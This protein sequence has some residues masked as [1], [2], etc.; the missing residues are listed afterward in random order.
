MAYLGVDIGGTKTLVGVLDDSGVIQ[1]ELKFPTPKD[2]PEFLTGLKKTIEGFKTKEFKA[3]GVAA[4]GSLDRK[5]GV[6]IALGNLP[7]INV[8]MKEDVEKVTNS[9]VVIENDAGLAGLSEAQLVKNEY[10]KVLYLTISTGI[11]G[12]IIIDGIIQP[13]FADTEP[14]QME[15]E[16]NGSMQKWEDFASGR[17]IVEEYGKQAHEINDPVIWR[18][19]ANN[20]SPGILTLT[21]ILQP[22]VIIFGGG[23]GTYFDRYKDFLSEALD[24]YSNPLIIKP[25]LR[26]AGRPE[27]AVVYGCYDLAK[28]TYGND[29]N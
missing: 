5:H 29:N 24:K 6:V 16:H 26:V 17:A 9:P 21:A 1:E 14:G 12:G 4:P 18:K 27:K 13:D 8:P 7:W 28:A 3:T 19:I 23:V 25:D 11:G 10:K 15:L 20:L 22:E 2:Y